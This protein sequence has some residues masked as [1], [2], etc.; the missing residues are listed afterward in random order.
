[1]FAVPWSLGAA[2][3]A[4]GREKFDQFYRMLLGGKVEDHPVPETLDSIY[5]SFPENGQVYDYYYEVRSLL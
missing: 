4:D 1:L 5:V 2:I 3:D